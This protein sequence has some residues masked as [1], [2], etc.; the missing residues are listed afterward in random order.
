M[1]ED[2][3]VKDRLHFHGAYISL[4]KPHDTLTN[5]S[6]VPCQ[7]W[8]VGVM[9]VTSFALTFRPSEYTFQLSAVLAA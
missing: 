8:V 4:E 6:T 2:T 7:E 3:A 5:E 1:L 9:E